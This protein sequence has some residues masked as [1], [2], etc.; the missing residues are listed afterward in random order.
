MSRLFA[1]TTP[2]FDRASVLQSAAFAA[3]AAGLPAAAADPAA[4]SRT[5]MWTSRWLCVLRVAV[6]IGRRDRPAARHRQVPSPLTLDGAGPALRRKVDGDV[7]HVSATTRALEVPPLD[8]VIG[9]N[10]VEHVRRVLCDEAHAGER[11]SPLV[12]L[13]VEPRARALAHGVCGNGEQ[14]DEA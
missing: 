5:R 1:S 9:P 2:L 4:A 10:D 7:G 14:Q 13:R 3:I 12:V 6:G 8:A 11:G